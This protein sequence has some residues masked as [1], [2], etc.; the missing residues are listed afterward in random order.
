MAALECTLHTHS[1]LKWNP[2]IFLTHFVY[3]A[4]VNLF[5]Q[6]QLSSAALALASACFSQPQHMR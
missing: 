6:Q 5:L 3:I 4:A 1:V 2:Q